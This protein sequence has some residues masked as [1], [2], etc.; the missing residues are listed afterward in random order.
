MIQVL[1]G[2]LHPEMCIKVR[3][4]CR[5]TVLSNFTRQLINKR[6]CCKF[7]SQLLM[8]EPKENCFTICQ[9]LK[10]VIT[11]DDMCSWIQPG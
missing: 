9:N 6:N 1:E 3:N 8:F 4:N 7:I 2:C 10:I 5:L 11:G